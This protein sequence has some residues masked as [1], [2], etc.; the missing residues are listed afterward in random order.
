MTHR[1]MRSS[2]NDVARK[3][4]DGLGGA[5]TNGASQRSP[6]GAET[7]HGT[8]AT[9]EIMNEKLKWDTE[10]VVL[11]AGSR[12]ELNAKVKRLAEYVA[13]STS[14]SLK[15]LAASCAEAFGENEHRLA[16]VAGS[17]EELHGRLLR[18]SQ[19]LDDDE[20]RRI[21]DGVGIY[22]TADPLHPNGKLAFLF[23]GEGAQY[24]GMMGGLE[25]HFPSVG[26]HFDWGDAA[27]EAD[28]DEP[29]LSRF[30][31]L[32]RDATKQQREEMERE[33]RKLDNAMV[34]VL[35]ADWAMEG[36]LCRLGLKPDAIAGH[37]AGELSALW[38]AGCIDPEAE[39]R[40]IPEMRDALRE[41]E[42][43]K[44]GEEAGLLAVGASREKAAEVI[45]AVADKIES[46]GQVYIAMDNCPHQT[47]LVGHATAINAVEAELRSRKVMHERLPFSKPYHTHLFEPYLGKLA[48]L[49]EGV[50]FC[51]PSIP[52]YSCTTGQP[53]PPDP[54]EIRRLML[55]HWAS[56]VEFR[57]MIENMYADGVHIFVEVG[58]R[59]NL[60]SFV[61]DILRGKDIL[62]LPADVQHRSGTTQ[63][64]HF[65]GQLVAHHVPVQLPEL[66]VRRDPKL[67]EWDTENAA[68]PVEPPIAAPAAQTTK[69][70]ET[71][72][73]AAHPDAGTA[74]HATEQRL[75]PAASGEIDNSPASGTTVNM[76]HRETV[77]QRH[78][79]VMDQFMTDQKLVVEAFLKN[80]RRGTGRFGRGTRTP[81]R[82]S[83][84]RPAQSRSLVP[85]TA[86]SPESASSAWPLMGDVVE[87][88]P[89]ARLVMR[90]RMDVAEDCY[91]AEHTVGGRDVSR[92]DPNQHGLPVMPM[93]FNLELMAEV[94]S[95]LVPGHV[96]LGLENVQLQRWL[97]FDDMPT[98]IQVTGEVQENGKS[99]EVPEATHM[100][101]VEVSDLG[102]VDAANVSK[103]AVAA[104]GTV[105]LGQR[106]PQPPLD[107]KK[108]SP[109][110]RKPKAT[111]A[112]MYKNL[113]HG[114]QFQGVIALDAIGE[115][116]IHS[117][118][119]VQPRDHLFSS[120]S[121]PHFLIDPVTVDV[122]M[123]PQAAWHL[124]QPDQS[125]RILLPYELKA[126][127]FYGPSPAVG[128]E[129]T[130]RAYVRHASVR[131]FVNEGDVIRP[132]GRI[133]CR[134]IGVRS[135]RFY[136]PFGEVNFHGPKDEYFLTKDWQEAIGEPTTADDSREDE[137][138]GGRGAAGD[139]DS[140]CVRLEP[141]ADLLQPALQMAAVQ[142]T[143][144]PAEKRYL[145]DLPGDPAY[146][147]NL[148]YE[149]IAA[150]DAVRILWRLQTG[151]RLFPAD[152]EI[153]A[154]DYGRLMARPR[155]GK[156]GEQ[157]PRVAAASCGQTMVAVAT[158]KQ[159]VGVAL[160]S[161]TKEKSE[162]AD[163]AE[164]ETNLIDPKSPKREE[165]V[166]RFRCAKQAVANALGST[167]VDPETDLHVRGWNA[168][169][170]EVE[171]ALATESSA[172]FPEFL[173][174][175]IR[176][177]TH[178]REQLLVATTFCETGGDDK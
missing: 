60:T 160:V 177:T 140:W 28:G 145:R 104:V 150:K 144:S 12:S 151:D 19:R 44:I 59:G 53:F 96:I 106:Y 24:A 18:A 79:E 173:G 73:P 37:S 75:P 146:R 88:E 168:E 81:R 124:E 35:V 3:T 135:W 70:T 42:S 128:D 25:E 147:T 84:D 92:V 66:F 164:E 148:L 90:R 34:S 58:P 137:P 29:P 33:L 50:S 10:L 2:T 133:W 141:S 156:K 153:E 16:V 162:F 38:A 121:L 76:S 98:M 118:I 17:T 15:D 49:F 115:N 112:Q 142:V 113:F 64:N 83:H 57:R 65:V 174:N 122:A 36:V 102:T 74:R 116:E 4:A 105:L 136:L 55:A 9:N 48:E 103:A 86:P 43:A 91:A 167:L 82:G 41:Q 45:L 89:G 30:M 126:V 14:V 108:I 21:S 68:T 119:K 39:L 130:C 31:R 161:P 175:L 61:S 109:D 54:L 94:A 107:A 110:V 5:P 134:L 163:L 123:H 176:V 78:F 99:D 143:M 131:Q 1:M 178:R 23:P 47:V 127:L 139:E 71:V 170:G 165:T 69:P 13:G 114:P 159:R 20:C 11:S 85:Y 95:L 67:F 80:R 46:S 40:L 101:R 6:A 154:D 117:R 111:L 157:F 77:V 138:F 166:A 27:L 155:G 7:S 169:S 62:A 100:V 129:F 125:G 97:A 51:A 72:A 8:S 52:I 32:P 22:Y 171:V 26:E 152:F 93:T 149:R 63:L 120:T 56:P 172:T 158:M 87:H 132:D